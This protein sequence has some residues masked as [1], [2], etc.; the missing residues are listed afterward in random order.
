M[1]RRLLCEMKLGKKMYG[2]V[3]MRFVMTFQCLSFLSKSP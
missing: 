1:K 3:G 2:A